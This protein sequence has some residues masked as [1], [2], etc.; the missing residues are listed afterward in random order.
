MKRVKVTKATA[1][2]RP[3]PAMELDLR[4]PAGRKLPY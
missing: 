3:R 1:M 2:R 4:S